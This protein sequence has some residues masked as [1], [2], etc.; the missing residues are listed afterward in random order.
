MA[1]RHISSE[2]VNKTI[3]PEAKLPVHPEFVPPDEL[4]SRL[5][6]EIRK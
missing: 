2:Q 1:E 6:E 3:I 5:L 4:L